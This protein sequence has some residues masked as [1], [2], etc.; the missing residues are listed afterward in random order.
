MKVYLSKL[1]IVNY[2][3]AVVLIIAVTIAYIAFFVWVI[4]TWAL[5]EVLLPTIVLFLCAFFMWDLQY[6]C[7]IPENLL[8][9]M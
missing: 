5:F 8:F 1:W 7:C 2:I 6:I 4:R 9:D 3:G